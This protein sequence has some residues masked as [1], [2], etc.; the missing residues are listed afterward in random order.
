MTLL[1]LLL[2]L[3]LS[4]SCLCVQLVY[5]TEAMQRVPTQLLQHP[6]M[7]AYSYSADR[8]ELELRESIRDPQ[9]VTGMR[10]KGEGFGLPSY[11]QPML[12]DDALYKQLQACP[13][14]LHKKISLCKY[15]ADHKLCFAAASLQ[16]GFMRYSVC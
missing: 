3:L 8:S 12:Q 13:Y 2:M 9:R 7:S 16:A 4:G 6:N 11:T 15:V 10:N 5:P 1:M 14:S